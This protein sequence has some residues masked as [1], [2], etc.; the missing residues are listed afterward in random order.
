MCVFGDSMIA[1][2]DKTDWDMQLIEVQWSLNHCVS[3][4]TKCKPIDVIH[5]YTAE[6]LN[7]NPLISEVKQ[8]NKKLVLGPPQ[9][10]S[11]T[12]LKENFEIQKVK[13]ST[14]MR[15]R[16]KYAEGDLVLVRWEAAGR[17]GN[18][19]Q[20]IDGHTIITRTLRFDRPGERQSSR[21]YKGVVGIGFNRL[22]LVKV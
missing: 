4:I 3:R 7:E 2:D 22:K 14:R 1:K 8:L 19:N 15:T 9:N 13:V 21:P 6:G 17:V 11:T 5:N 16:E 20:N 12:Q 18:S 10:D